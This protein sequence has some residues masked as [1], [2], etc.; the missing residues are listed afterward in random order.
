MQ[1]SIAAMSARSGLVAACTVVMLLLAS[2]GATLP[3]GGPVGVGPMPPIGGAAGGG[4]DPSW[5]V[6]QGGNPR[7]DYNCTLH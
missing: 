7:A 5:A 4:L 3:S 6:C 1:V 2:C